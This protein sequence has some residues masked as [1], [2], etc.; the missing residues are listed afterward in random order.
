MDRLISFVIGVPMMLV[1][2][3]V[4]IVGT[5]VGALALLAISPLVVLFGQQVDQK[6]YKLFGIEVT[7]PV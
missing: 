3:F 6:K 7:V 5:A 4:A 1:M 2:L